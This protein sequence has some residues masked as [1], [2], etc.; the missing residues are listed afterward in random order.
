MKNAS[1]QQIEKRALHRGLRIHRET[2]RQLTRG[3]LRQAGG[4]IKPESLWTQ[5]EGGCFPTAECPP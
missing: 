4:G 3:E 2:L 5:C 1:K